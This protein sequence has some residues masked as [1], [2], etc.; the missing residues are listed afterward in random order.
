MKVKVTYTL[1]LED[2]PSLVSDMIQECKNKLESA[3]KFRFDFNSF[4]RS[5]RT[6][7]E[8]QTQLEMIT[9]QLDDCVNLTQGYLS[10][11]NPQPVI[12]PTTAPEED[13]A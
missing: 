3:S 7:S 11:N 1:D 2:V 9:A 10:A 4:E 12:E 6:V 8:I 13:D 5:A